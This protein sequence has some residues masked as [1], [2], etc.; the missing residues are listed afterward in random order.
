MQNLFRDN[1][2]FEKDALGKIIGELPSWLSGTLVRTGPGKWDLDEEFSMNHFYD[3]CAMM[4]RFEFDQKEKC[5]RA[6]SRFL[7]SDAYRKCCE[8]KRPVY[9]EFGTQAHT[10][11][12]RGLISRVFT[13]IVPSDLTDNEI[14]NIYKINDDEIY[15]TTESCNIWKIDPNNLDGL[16]KI[17]LDKKPGVAICCSHPILSEDERVMYNV[18][19]TFLTGMKYHIMRIPIDGKGD[20]QKSTLENSQIICSFNSS[21]KGSFAYNHSFAITKNFVIVIE[22][23]LLVNGLKLATCTP[24]GKSLEDCLEWCPDQPSHFHVFDK[25]SNTMTKHKFETK[26]FFYFHSINAYEEDDQIVLDILN[27]D[28]HGLLETLRMKNLRAGKFETS[29]KSKPMRYVLPVRDLKLM[30]KNENLV[31]IETSQSTAILND[32]GIITL[33][34]EQLGPSGSEMPTINPKYVGK[35]YN[36]IYASGFLETGYYENAI[37]KLDIKKNENVIYKHSS[38]TYPGEGV[39]IASP[40]SETEDDG[41]ILTLCLE[42]DLEKNPFLAVLDAKSFKELARVEFDRREVSIPTTIHGLWLPNK[43]VPVV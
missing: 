29:S 32:K 27:Y 38:T 36:F 22:Q 14:A 39:F 37:A 20:K 30:R 11:H 18:G 16:L 42:S 33:E 1:K 25:R 3:G 7:N 5:V 23:S 10:D 31:T 4:V 40:N 17:N 21:Y 26:G 15:M 34:G 6:R 8:Q 24:K 28:D 2:E 43:D 35:P 41:I 12:S 19:T 13:R 9:T